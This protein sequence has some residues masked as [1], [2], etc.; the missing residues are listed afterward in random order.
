MC[1]RPGER[2]AA[3]RG[4][5]ADDPGS[6]QE[7]NQRLDSSAVVAC[8]AGAEARSAVSAQTE[9]RL[10]ASEMERQQLQLECQR[11]QKREWAWQEA[12]RAWEEARQHILS[13]DS[14][15]G[16]S[17]YDP[18]DMISSTDQVRVDNRDHYQWAISGTE[19]AYHA[20]RNSI[21]HSDD[22]S[23]LVNKSEAANGCPNP[24][25]V[26]HI[27]CAMSGT[28]A[29]CPAPRRVC[30]DAEAGAKEDWH[31]WDEV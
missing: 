15:L 30:A 12:A 28:D 20:V 22:N 17:R 9:Q 7:G 13:I 10:R 1:A 31:V 16:G 11:L 29:A 5:G 27:R 19:A 26:L 21:K 6:D 4:R 25:F 2:A 24:P 14:E 3:A 8:F 23:R 18:P